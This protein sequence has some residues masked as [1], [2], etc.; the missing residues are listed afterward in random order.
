MKPNAVFHF[1][2]V[3]LICLFVVVPSR[4]VAKTRQWNDYLVPFRRDIRLD[5]STSSIEVRFPDDVLKNDT[6]YDSVATTG[7]PMWD[8]ETALRPRG[9][10]LLSAERAEGGGGLQ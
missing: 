1:F 6:Q 4:I 7:F 8:I 2:A 3:V 10:Y 5:R 9:L